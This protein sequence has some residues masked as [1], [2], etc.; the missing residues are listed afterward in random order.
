MPVGSVA[1]IRYGWRLTIRSNDDNDPD[2]SQFGYRSGSITKCAP[3]GCRVAGGVRSSDAIVSGPLPWSDRCRV[4]GGVR[5]SIPLLLSRRCSP[6]PVASVDGH[7]AVDIVGSASVRGG[8][9][10]AG[11]GRRRVSASL[12]GALAHLQNIL[13]HGHG[14]TV[15]AVVGRTRR[16]CG[17]AA[18]AAIGGAWWGCRLTFGSSESRGRVFGG[19]KRK[20]MIEIKQLRLSSLHPRVAHPHR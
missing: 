17:A 10:P 11:I 8:R 3:R 4:L 1:D 16:I 12:G 7:S 14:N 15:V 20:S 6:G 13:R 5:S 2:T 19:L 9:V 18:M